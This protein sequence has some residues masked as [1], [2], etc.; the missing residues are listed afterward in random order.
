VIGYAQGVRTKLYANPHSCDTVVNWCFYNVI[1][2][3]KQEFFIEDYPNDTMI[4]ELRSCSPMQIFLH[5]LFYQDIKLTSIEGQEEKNIPYQFEGT[6]L[7]FKLPSSSCSLKLSYAFTSDYFVRADNSASYIFTL[8]TASNSWYFTCDNMNID[9]A[10]IF[11]Y[12]SV[13]ILTNLPYKK[14]ENKMVM[15]MSE[16]KEEDGVIFVF[17]ERSYFEKFSFYHKSNKINLFINKEAIK[18][19][20]PNDTINYSVYPGNR[21]TPELTNRYI[22]RVKS[23]IDELDSIIF[24]LENS[25]INIYD[26]VLLLKIEEAT[27]RWGAAFPVNKDRQFTILI[28]T[29]DAFESNT[30]IHELIHAYYSNLT[31]SANDTTHLF[32]SEGLTEYLAKYVQYKD[33]LIRDSAFHY[34]MIDNY[35]D[36]NY[37]FSIFQKNNTELGEYTITPFVIHVF[38]QIVGEEKFLSILNHFFKEVKKQGYFSMTLL[39]KLMK[40]NNVTNKQWNWFIKNL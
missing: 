14:I 39:E 17:L 29:S 21:V 28:D 12:D 33:R 7:S 40:E 31:P 16:M 25:E 8:G 22:T 4:I 26:A 34:D 23:I 11:E 5:Y 18:I 3:V 32:F 24:P 9:Y 15:D 20:K 1:V 6:S 13:Y 35:R 37:E 2:D 30:I 38:A 19:P 10:E 36:G 27:Y